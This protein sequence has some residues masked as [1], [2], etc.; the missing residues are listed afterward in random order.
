MCLAP[1]KKGKI[2]AY[3][4]CEITK[5]PYFLFRKI[6]KKPIYNYSLV[7]LEYTLAKLIFYIMT[8]VFK[9]KIK[10]IDTDYYRPSLIRTKDKWRRCKR[11]N[12]T[13]DIKEFK[14]YYSGINGYG[15]IICKDCNHS[16]ETTFFLHR[17]HSSTTG[18]QCQTCGLFHSIEDWKSNEELYCDCGGK[19]ERD[20]QIFC[21]KCKS[22]NVKN[23]THYMY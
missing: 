1:H 19:L 9:R 20:N 10:S 21:P 18:L 6:Y 22:K 14:L 3:I 16:E 13:S 17:K 8:Y 4:T 2:C 11:K 7:K 12:N 5:L 15:D 23:N